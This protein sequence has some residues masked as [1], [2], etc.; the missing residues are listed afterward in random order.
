MVKK[1][2]ELPSVDDLVIC[3]ITKVFS[4][5]A[6]AKLDEYEDKVGFIHI[7]EIASTWIKNV[8]DFVRKGQKTVAKVLN[9]DPQKGHV[10]LSTRRVSD[11][12]KKNKMQDWKRAQKAD[13]LLEIAA[14]KV[15][16]S[17]DS[18]Y[19]EVGFKLEEKYGEIYSGLEEA[20]ISGEEAFA[21]LNISKSW[22]EQL[23]KIA[24]ENISVPFVCITGYVDLR[25]PSPNGVEVIKKALISA[26]DKKVEKGVK[27]DIKY[28]GSPRYSIKVVAPNYKTAEE[29][30]KRCAED[31]VSAVIKEGGTGKFLRDV[32]EEK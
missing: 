19:D 7:S 1:R 25:C 20:S 6:F 18:A 27:V 26:R 4:H 24:K 23:V 30:L 21:G 11:A 29:Y 28:V 22:I 3:T 15:G 16:K 17:I 8:R 2:S 12:Q 32:K 31:A 14:R 5:G 10:D 13:K 9:V